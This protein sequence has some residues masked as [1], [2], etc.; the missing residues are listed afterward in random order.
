MSMMKLNQ[1]LTVLIQRLVLSASDS[2]PAADT[3]AAA[4]MRSTITQYFQRQIPLSY[5]PSNACFPKTLTTS[6]QNVTLNA[7][8][9]KWYNEEIFRCNVTNAKEAKVRRKLA[10]AIYM[11]KRF[12]P[13]GTIIHPKPA[14]LVEYQLWTHQIKE[15]GLLSEQKILELCKLDYEN[16]IADGQKKRKR[17]LK[18]MLEGMMKRL[19]NI[20]KNKKELVTNIVSNVIDNAMPIEDDLN[21]EDPYVA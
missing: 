16:D 3:P 15:L 10:Y 5:T 14:T 18:P 17:T 20:F 2:S 9:H 6:L 4:P 8:F 21:L 11:M 7:L 13:S 1:N 19:G 12:L